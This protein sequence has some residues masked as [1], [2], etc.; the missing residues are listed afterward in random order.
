MNADDQPAMNTDPT[1]QYR[2]LLEDDPPAFLDRLNTPWDQVPDLERLSPQKVS[3]LDIEQSA[4]FV[5]ADDDCT[6]TLL[7]VPQLL[8][9]RPRCTQHGGATSR[10][11]RRRNTWRR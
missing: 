8:E 11:A 3:N 1:N 10:P 6:D 4:C 5:Q 9:F 7:R 2:P